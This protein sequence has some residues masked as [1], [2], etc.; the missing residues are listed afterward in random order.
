MV[1]IWRWTNN[2]NPSYSLSVNGVT[3]G[4][5][6]NS[7]ARYNRGFG[8]I[9]AYHE[10]NTTP[11]SASQFWGDIKYFAVYNRRLLDSELLTCYNALQSYL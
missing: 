9:G 1:M 5:I 7:N 2:D 10:G 8:S 6:V 4:N 11:S 3:V